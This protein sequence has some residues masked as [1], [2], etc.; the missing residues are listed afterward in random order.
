M[1]WCKFSSHCWIRCR[2]VFTRKCYDVVSVS[3]QEF[4]TSHHLEI[5]NIPFLKFNQAPPFWLLT[6]GSS[7]QLTRIDHSFATSSPLV[8]VLSIS[9]VQPP[10]FISSFTTSSYDFFGLSFFICP[11][12]LSSLILLT[13]FVSSILSRFPSHLSL[14]SPRWF[15]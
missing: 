14:V 1:Y 15:S 7:S 10:F 12:T 2:F 3:F 8:S 13:K 6:A 9:D 11:G 4:K 5:L